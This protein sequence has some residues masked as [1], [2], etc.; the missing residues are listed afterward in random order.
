MIFAPYRRAAFTASSIVA[1][2]VTPITVI[3][4][5]PAFAAISISNAPV[6]IVFR[7]ATMV[8]PGNSFRS[9]RRT[10]TPSD[11]IRGVPASIQSAP[12]STASFAA[13]IARFACMKSRATCRT[14]SIGPGATVRRRKNVSRSP[15]HAKAPRPAT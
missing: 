3:T 15:G 13:W 11:L 9:C 1:S 2:S 14:G 10:S 8:L 7:S 4:S 5:A 12:P 6:S